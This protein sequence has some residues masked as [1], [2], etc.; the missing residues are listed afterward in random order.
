MILLLVIARALRRYFMPPPFARYAAFAEIFD[1]V[2]HVM[3]R[4]CRY[5]MRLLCYAATLRR[6][7]AA[8][9]FVDAM[10]P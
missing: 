8:M 4:A 9:P 5:A 1:V 7:A 6:H 2:R 3:L 10:P